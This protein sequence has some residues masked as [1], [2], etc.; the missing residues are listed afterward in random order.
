MKKYALLIGV[1]DYTDDSLQALPAATQD[2]AE[3]GRVLE[4]AELGGFE[5]PEKGGHSKAK[6]LARTA[7]L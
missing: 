6:C 7:M 2:A 5:E 3:L 4:M 1:S